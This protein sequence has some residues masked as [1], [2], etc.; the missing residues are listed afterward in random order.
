MPEYK[1]LFQ[2]DWPKGEKYLLWL[3]KDDNAEKAWYI[4]FKSFSVA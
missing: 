2:D 1:S 3:Q 4:C